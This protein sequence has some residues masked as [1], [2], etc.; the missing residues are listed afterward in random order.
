MP[1]SPSLVWTEF[2]FYLLLKWHSTMIENR[3]YSK[4]EFFSHSN[5]LLLTFIHMQPKKKENR[6]GN[7][8]LDCK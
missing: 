2:P 4:A 6:K 5:V 1:Q 3:K 8:S 7:P